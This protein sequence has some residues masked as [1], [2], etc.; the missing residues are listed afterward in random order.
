[1]LFSPRS[2]NSWDNRK[3]CRKLTDKIYAQD[4]VWQLE[5]VVELHG[6]HGTTVDDEEDRG[7][8]EVC[9]LPPNTHVK[10]GVDVWLT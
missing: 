3:V 2:Y 7:H 1:M 5:S 9:L 8:S 6:H 4:R 10:R